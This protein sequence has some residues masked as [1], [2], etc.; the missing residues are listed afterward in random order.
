MIAFF[1]LWS[2][3]ID[4]NVTDLCQQEDSRIEA[5]VLKILKIIAE[6]P[7]RGIRIG[8]PGYVGYFLFGHLA[9]SLNYLSLCSSNVKEVLAEYL[10]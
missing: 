2:A 10:I 3:A 5:Y 8:L 1:F 4:T 9:K 6:S 7:S